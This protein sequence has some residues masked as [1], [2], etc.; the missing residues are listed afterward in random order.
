MRGGERHRE[1]EKERERERE[2]ERRG[3]RKVY[4][5]QKERNREDN[6]VVCVRGWEVERRSKNRERVTGIESGVS[7]PCFELIISCKYK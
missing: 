1:R 2:R 5:D 7:C 6:Y 3:E 4:K